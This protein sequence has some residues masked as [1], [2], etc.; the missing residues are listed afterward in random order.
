MI[1]EPI[2]DWLLVIVNVYRHFCVP[3]INYVQ[4]LEPRN[5]FQFYSGHWQH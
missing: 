2:D 3:V 4:N 5:V 1:S